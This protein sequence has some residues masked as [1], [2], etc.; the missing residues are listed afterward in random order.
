MAE[1]TEPT[2]DFSLPILNQTIKEI[3]PHRYPF[4]LVDRI[5]DLE[6][7]KEIHAFKN[8]TANEEYFNGHFPHQAVMPGVLQLEAMAQ[9]AALLVFYSTIQDASTKIAYLMSMDSVK[10]RRL[11]VPGDRLDLHV[12][13]IKLKRGLCKV[14]ARATV[15]G[16]KAS[17]AVITAAIR[18]RE[19]V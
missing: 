10:F 5:V 13:V 18:D 9:A 1:I 15:D 3:L 4:L 17:E 19:S 14:N 12:E 6:P 8:V 2:H 11:V 16:E 7:G